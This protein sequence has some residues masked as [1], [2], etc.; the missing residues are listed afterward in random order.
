MENKYQS[1][2]KYICVT[3]TNIATHTEAIAMIATCSH[4]RFPS[5][6]SYLLGFIAVYSVEIQT[7]FRKSMLRSSEQKSKQR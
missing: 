4:S 2:K 7:T 6:D 3:S 5:K 1:A